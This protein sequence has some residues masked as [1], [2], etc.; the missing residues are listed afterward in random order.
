MS[1]E[2]TTLVPVTL[3]RLATSLDVAV[4]DELVIR[5][6]FRSTLD[7]SIVDASATLDGPP[8]ADTGG[9]LDLEGGGLHVVSRD[10]GRHEVRVVVQEIAPACA[11]AG[12]V[13][14]CLALRLLPQA[15]SRLLTMADWKASL[16]GGLTVAVPLPIVPP[17]PIVRAVPYAAI[18]MFFGAIVFAIV[19]TRTFVRRRA[20]SPQGRLLA[21]L[22]RLEKKIA[23][24]EPA[25]VVT[26][27]P[28]LAAANEAVS[29]RR[30]D[31]SS[32]QGARIVAT[33]GRIEGRLDEA[34]QRTREG[35]ER[36]VADELVR[37]M[38]VAVRAAEEVMAM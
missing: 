5:G 11:K 13:P 28:T 18:V 15:Q 6:A 25:L 1:T 36:A 9:I 27:L 19:A 30:I 17:A 12:V 23:K 21:L 7:G 24:A 37:E 31:A 16:G 29:A 35:R 22:R 38:E 2:Q 4:G 33:L 20:A 3:D 32:P 26:L 34:T 14:P 10:L 8:G